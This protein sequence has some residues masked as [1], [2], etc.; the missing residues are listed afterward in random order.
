MEIKVSSQS[1]PNSVAG[2]IANLL[3]EGNEKV[4][5]S[6]IG[7]GALN[8]SIKAV[9]IARGFVAPLG[10]DLI[11]VPSFKQIELNGENRTAMKI[12]VEIR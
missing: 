3:K 6:C 5:I 12:I 7:A 4:E 2:M 8:Q 9:C 11:C 10:M 1:N